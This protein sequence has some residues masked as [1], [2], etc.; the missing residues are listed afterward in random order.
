[1][2]RLSSNWNFKSVTQICTDR[3]KQVAAAMLTVS[4]AKSHNR[5]GQGRIHID[6]VA[7]N[8]ARKNPCAEDVAI[9]G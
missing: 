8:A 6:K 1:L 9:L 2:H 5:D 7:F 4:A 3:A